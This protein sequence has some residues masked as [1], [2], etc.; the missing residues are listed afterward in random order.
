MVDIEDLDLA[1]NETD[2][3]E[4][5]NVSVIVIKHLTL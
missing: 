3:N 5:L 1:T 2:E 4:A